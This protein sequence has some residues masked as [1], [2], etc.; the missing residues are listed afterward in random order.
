MLRVRKDLFSSTPVQMGNHSGQLVPKTDSYC[1][2]TAK[3]I[4]KVCSLWS[5]NKGES[6]IKMARAS[7]A[8]N[9]EI[10]IQNIN[11]MHKQTHPTW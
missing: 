3:F 8:L 5:M 2:D 4:D 9:R 7:D 1:L 10:C 6:K 11:I